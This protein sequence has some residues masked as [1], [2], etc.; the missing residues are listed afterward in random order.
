VIASIDRLS[1]PDVRSVAVEADES[2]VDWCLG[3]ALVV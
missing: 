3:A 1:L 2:P